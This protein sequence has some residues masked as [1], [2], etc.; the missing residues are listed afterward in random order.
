MQK[1]EPGWRQDTVFLKKRITE[2]NL[3]PHIDFKNDLP[4]IRSAMAFRP[5]TAAPLSALA[6]V[7]MRSDEGLTRLE[8]EIIGTY[9]S[10]LNGCFYCNHSHAAIASIYAGDDGEMI[11]SVR[12]DYTSA[13]ISAKLKSLL[14]IAAK[15]RQSGKLVETDDVEKARREGATD[16]DIHDT[17]LIAAAFSLFNRYVDGLA[18]VTPV[19]MT[20]YPV[21]AKQVADHGYGAHIYSPNP[22]KTK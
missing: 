8:R 5:E 14:A 4:G 15:V 6:K 19:D 11:D 22:M 1:W 13:P 21:R 20:S 9:V 17:V 16:K 2:N 10:H 7:L 18:T 3:M 12:A